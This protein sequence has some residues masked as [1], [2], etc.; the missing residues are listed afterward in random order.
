MEEKFINYNIKFIFIKIGLSI[1]M[2]KLK[3]YNEVNPWCI[4]EL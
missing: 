2:I 4:R 3:N 1:K